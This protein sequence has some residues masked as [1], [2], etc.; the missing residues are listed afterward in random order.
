MI[1]FNENNPYPMDYYSNSSL[2][3]WTPNYKPDDIA[4]PSEICCGKCKDE[5]NTNKPC[6]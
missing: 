6:K 2:G 5:K 4:K 1:E 3:P